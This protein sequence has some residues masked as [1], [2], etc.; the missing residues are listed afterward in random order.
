VELSG[1]HNNTIVD[2]E[3]RPWMSD[4]TDGISVVQSDGNTFARNRLYSHWYGIDLVESN[5]NTIYR[6]E[7]AQ[8]HHTCIRT[9]SSHGNVILENDFFPGG[10]WENHFAVDITGNDNTIANNS[11]LGCWETCVILGGSRNLLANNS[12]TTF[13]S[14]IEVSGYDNR[15]ANNHIEGHLSSFTTIGISLMHAQRSS[16]EDNQVYGF[17]G[18]GLRLFDSDNNTITR[19]VVT[20]NGD[21]LDSYG[22]RLESSQGNRIFHNKLRYNNKQAYDDRA[23]NEWDN[24]YPSG[25]NYWSDHESPDGYKGPDQDI[26]GSDCIVDTARVI[27]LDSA[28]RY[29][30][31]ESCTYDPSPPRNISACLSG[32]GL[33]DVTVSW[34]ASSDEALGLVESYEIYRG[35]WYDPSGLTYP[36]RASIPTGEHSY[37]ELMAGEGNPGT[38]FFLVCARSFSGG[39][40]CADMQAAKFTRQVVQGPVLVSVPLVQSNESIERVLQTVKYDK[41]WSYDSSSGE[42]QWHMTAKE[43]GGLANLNHTMGLWVN[44]TEEC[45]LTVAGIVP[46]QTAIHLR[47]GW[48][49]IGYP[50]FNISYTV[51]DLKAELPVERVEGFDPTAPPHF[52]RVL[53]DS[54]FLR[55]GQGYWMKVSTDATLVVRNG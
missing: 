50:S 32:A 55:A 10:G 53:Q 28:D 24:G 2:N 36:F 3:L 42:W 37:T 25:G 4:W 6:N 27:D 38:Y 29:P 5:N 46:A 9:V 39:K 20:S 30:L 13:G 21:W 17:G 34:D 44:A 19:N 49:L 45:N 12:M 54:D 48:N 41:I 18:D 35:G 7:L 33:T 22:V 31:I 26:P 16:L 14:G 1:S 43:Y 11:M 15:I 52:L 23:D 47:S 8:H 51:G 40:M